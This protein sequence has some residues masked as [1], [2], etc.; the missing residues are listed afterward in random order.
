M[1]GFVHSMISLAVLRR[2]CNRDASVLPSLCR[3]RQ[4]SRRIPRRRRAHRLA[5][6][7]PDG[8]SRRYATKRCG[9]K[10]EGRGSKKRA[11]PQDRIDRPTLSVFHLPVSLFLSLLLLSLFLVRPH[12][13]RFPSISPRQRQRN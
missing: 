10:R 13:C 7:I 12:A 6:R 8:L 9:E 2:G 4:F 11:H 5:E 3:K 1:T